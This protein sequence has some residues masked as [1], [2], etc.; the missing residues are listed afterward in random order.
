MGPYIQM[1][2]V[3]VTLAM[4]EDLYR[5]FRGTEVNEP[6]NDQDLECF[7]FIGFEHAMS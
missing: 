3:A 2:S 4:E 6:S 7:T 1:G 5:W